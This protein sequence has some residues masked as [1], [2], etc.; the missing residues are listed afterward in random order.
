MSIAGNQESLRPWTSPD[1][2]EISLDD[3]LGYLIRPNGFEVGFGDG[4]VQ[5]ITPDIFLDNFK[6][7]LT[8]AG[9]EVVD[10]R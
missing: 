5:R 4:S 3:P 7:L 8:R 9:S 1:Y 6:A 10:I 2:L